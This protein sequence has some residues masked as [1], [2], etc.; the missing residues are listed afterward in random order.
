[1]FYWL[2]SIL[3]VSGCSSYY[4]SEFLVTLAKYLPT[5]CFFIFGKEIVSAATMAEI[6]QPI[7]KERRVVVYHL[8]KAKLTFRI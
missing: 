7:T 4:I 3:S 6:R 5:V 2:S 1:M 8:S